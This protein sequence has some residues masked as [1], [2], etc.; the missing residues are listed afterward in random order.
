MDMEGIRAYPLGMAQQ[1]QENQRVPKVIS[2]GDRNG[3]TWSR[4][5][6]LRLDGT[7]GLWK[8][9]GRRAR[10]ATTDAVPAGTAMH[11]A[12]A[13][14]HLADVTLGF[15][16][17]RRPGTRDL[18]VTLAELKIVP[19]DDGELPTEI[20][21][22]LGLRRLRTTMAEGVPWASKALIGS[23]WSDDVRIPRPGRR[24][25]PLFH[26]AEW[27]QRYVE[28]LETNPAN[29]VAQLASQ[30]HE[31]AGTI[32]A[33][34]QRAEDEGLLDRSG[35]APGVA[36]GRLTERCRQVLEEG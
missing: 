31:A 32:R 14:V 2:A 24:G 10:Y 16:R 13:W 35:V 4:V 28:M 6:S 33:W 8:R 9:T 22:R 34:L 36:G 7:V 30:H 19:A 12:G 3:V 5:S 15:E 11:S 23:S 1:T 21:T 29:P 25:R 18:E 27:A 26:F 20:L 17:R